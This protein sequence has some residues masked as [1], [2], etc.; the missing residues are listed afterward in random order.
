MPR[1]VEGHLYNDPA[2]GD[3]STIGDQIRVDYYKRKALID[4][5]KE[6]IFSPLADTETMPKH[7]GKR[8]RQYLYIPL[9]DD[10]NLTDQGI[11]ATGLSTTLKKTIV[12]KSPDY[13]D[14]A[15]YIRLSAVGEG[16]DEPTALA[17]AQVAAEKILREKGVLDTDYAT[18]KAKLEAQTPAWIFDEAIEA[19]PHTGNLYGSSK[20]IGTITA[21]L[22]VLSETG[23]RVN[24]VGYT[25]VT[26][27]SNLEKYGF[28]DEYS[29]DSMQFDSDAMLEEHTYREML[30]G[31][32]EITED[33]IQM[34]L[35]NAAGVVR[36]A[37]DA[38]QTSELNGEA[39]TESL[40]TYMDFVR[41]DI[42][43]D[44]NRCPKQTTI[45]KGS[46]M[47][48][49]RTIPSARVMFIG[50]E[51]Y[52]T[53]KGLKDLH[54]E[55]AFIPVHQYA[56]AGTL[57][58]GEV[59]TVDNFRIVVAREMQHWAGVGADATAAN[60]GYRETN[61]KYDVFPML[62]VGEKSFTCIGFQQGGKGAM[63]KFKI[64][65]SKP[66]SDT[67]YGHHDPYGEMGFRSIKWWYGKMIQRP[68]R[69]AL[70][71]T[72]APW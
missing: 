17:A 38:M 24:R 67:S 55:R 30:R 49:T 16:A 62:V 6:M 20:D 56:D 68:E 2:G 54:G 58:N 34:D 7:F 37:G 14:H 10:A 46:R 36:F 53:I 69:I 28:F 43:L 63:H 40:V 5:A 33:M 66:E 18:T 19:V 61:G 29:K 39:G 8:I 70:I 32:N 9:L 1:D 51:L 13:Y 11:D 3:Q 21:K 72:V 44:D 31:A 15:L 71:K 12:I 27:E 22:P 52:P 59:G 4:V 47:I 25:R 57:M 60:A 50:S 23:G 64:K 42:E 48:D 65:H 41:L 45:I 26:I 35:L